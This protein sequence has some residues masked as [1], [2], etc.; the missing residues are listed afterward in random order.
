MVLK[1]VTV[2]GFWNETDCGAS[3]LHPTRAGWSFAKCCSVCWLANL[4]ANMEFSALLHWGRWVTGYRVFT[5]YFTFVLQN[6]LWS[7]EVR[8]CMFLE[9]YYKISLVCML[10]G[11]CTA[12]SWEGSF[13]SCHQ[14]NASDEVQK[15]IFDIC[16]YTMFRKIED[17][18]CDS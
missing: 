16:E 15:C 18:D 4:F 1:R 8:L 11:C 7:H 17:N 13:F 12:P 10:S 6:Y 3:F 5:K 2:C 9:M 14:L